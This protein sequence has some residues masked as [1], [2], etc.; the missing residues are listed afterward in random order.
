M[1]IFAPSRRSGVSSSRQLGDW[2]PDYPCAART[3]FERR[4][5]MLSRFGDL[6]NTFALM[7]E[8]RRR[9]D[10][11]WDDSDPSWQGMTSSPGAFSASL[12]PRVNVYDGGANLVLKADV[13][14]LS[15]RDVEVTLN[16]GGLAI[17]GER[18]VAPPPGYSAHRQERS[19]VKF[20][21]SLELP[22]KVNPEQTTATVK[23]GVLTITLAKAA[24]A[25]PRQ[26][27]V[28]AQ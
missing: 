3:K 22:C 14:G 12:F 4:N 10:R 23:D 17:S 16:E 20:S 1:N 2:K 8:L 11:V 26:I 13:P 7:D 18:S 9:M 28:R 19:H 24:E 6:E 27:S 5:I 21:R 25:Q 15:E